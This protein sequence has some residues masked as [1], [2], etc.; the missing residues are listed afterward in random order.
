MKKITAVVF[1]AMSLLS[2][3]SSSSSTT[4]NKGD[5]VDCNYYWPARS[6]HVC[7]KDMPRRDC[8]DLFAGGMFN[9]EEACVCDQGG[10]EK[11]Q[12]QGTGYT[13]YDCK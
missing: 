2:Y 13:Q 9:R 1:I 11:N 4:S 12:V 6:R 10:K 8:N 5:V 3:C 7:I